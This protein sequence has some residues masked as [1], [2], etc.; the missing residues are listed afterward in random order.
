MTQAERVTIVQTWPG[1]RGIEVMV[2]VTETVDALATIT[3][4][5]NGTAEGW[6]HIAQIDASDPHAK[7]RAISLAEIVHDALEMADLTWKPTDPF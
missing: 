1:V 2:T 3:I 4:G 7:A 5:L 6:T